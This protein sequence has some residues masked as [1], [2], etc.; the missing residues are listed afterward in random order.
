[1][2]SSH[3]ISPTVFVMVGP[4]EGKTGIWGGREFKDG[5]HLFIGSIEQIA[6]V[7]KVMRTFGAYPEGSDA[8]EHAQEVYKALEERRA[9]PPAPVEVPPEEEDPGTEPS[10]EKFHNQRLVSAIKSLD[11]DDN[12]MWTKDGLPFIGWVE[13]FMASGGLNRRVVTDALPGWNRDMAREAKKI[14]DEAA[15]AEVGETE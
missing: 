12:R 3:Q 15:E 5:A 11:P 1:M 14:S 4:N 2:P 13:R 9:P 8:H 6:K 10:P 7:A